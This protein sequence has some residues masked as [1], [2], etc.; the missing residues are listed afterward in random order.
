VKGEEWFPLKRDMVAKLVVMDSA[1]DDGKTL[2]QTLCQEFGK[3]NT[4]EGMNFTT[5]KVHWLSKID[6]AK[7]VGSLVIWLKN[8]LAAD[9]LLSSGTAIFGATGAYCSKWEKRDKNLPCSTCLSLQAI[10]GMRPIQ[11]RQLYRV[12]VTPVL[13]YAASAWYGPGKGEFSGL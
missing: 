9:H 6:M 2:Q 10:K 8:K 1:V 5:M 12:C 13:D 7:K 11:L 3:E 4:V